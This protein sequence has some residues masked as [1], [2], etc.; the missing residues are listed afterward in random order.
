MQFTAD[1]LLAIKFHVLKFGLN[2]VLGMPFLREHN[3]TI[4][5]HARTVTVKDIPLSVPHSEASE[6]EVVC[7]KV[8]A[9][10][11]M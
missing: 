8:F 2:C 10:G 11:V 1:L 7:S 9:A 6:V 3:P 4:D 5:W